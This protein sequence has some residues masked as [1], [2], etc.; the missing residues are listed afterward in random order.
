MPMT[1]ATSMARTTA[2]ADDTSMLSLQRPGALLRQL[3]LDT[4]YLLLALPMGILTFTVVVTGWAVSLG[5]AITLVGLP[6][7]MATIYVSR[8]MAWV[9]RR[10]AAL[11][12]GEPIPGVYKSRHRR[13]P[14]PPQ[15]ALLRSVDVEGP[16]LAPAAAAG[17]HRR[18]HH[19][20]DGVVG[21]A[22][23]C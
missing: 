4:V 3:G 17:R 19:R 5:L 12:L 15:G 18:L 13:L 10:R 23:A 1:P 20:G 9:E 21:L 7:A 22:A 2:T 8:W 16:R 11:V 14:G 6:L